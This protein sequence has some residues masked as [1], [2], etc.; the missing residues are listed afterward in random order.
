MREP[1]CYLEDIRIHCNCYEG[2]EQ[3]CKEEL[4]DLVKNYKHD[5]AWYAIRFTRFD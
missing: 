5:R 4:E 1:K 3:E 2:T